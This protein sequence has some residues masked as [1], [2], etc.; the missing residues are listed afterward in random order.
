MSQAVEPKRLNRALGL[1]GALFIVLS[2]ITPASSVFIIVPGVIGLSG[3]GALWSFI[4]AAVIGLVMAF[5]YAELS[6]AFPTAGGEYTMIGRTMGPF[7]GFVTMVLLM[8]TLVLIIAVIAFGVGQY[9]GVVMPGLNPLATAI[10]AI[11]LAAVIAALGI[12]QNAL[13]TGVFL[14]IELL[15]L[16]ILVVLG[17]GGAERSIG[18]V[19]STPQV[20]D[21]ATNALA[22]AP[23]A[24][25]LAATA[26]ALFAYNGYGGAAYFGEETK[27]AKRSIG[28]V[29]LW[30]LLVTVLAEVLPLIAVLMGSPDLQALLAAPQKIEYF[31]EAKGGHSL[32]VLVSLAIVV[33]IFNAVIAIMLQ[34]ARLLYSTARDKTWPGGINQPLARLHPNFAS[35]W[36]ATVVVAVLAALACFIDFNTLLVVTGTSLIVVYV[37]LCIGVIIG[38]NN[39]STANGH[40][41]MPGYPIPAVLALI[42]L[43]YIAYQNLMDAAFGRPS[44]A[45]TAII[46]AIA[47]VYYLVFLARREDWKQEAPM[48]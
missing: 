37:L 36:I 15:A 24:A 28:R 23:F 18:A 21:T 29:I 6:S 4:I 33:A 16:L 1:M 43:L 2:A 30:A 34:A 40:Y 14:A 22:P 39:G 8:V 31:L 42:A 3:T 11:L 38:R 26:V 32:T 17:F 13:I 20:L 44:F 27:D 48:E 41:R 45:A 19:L 9:L 25:I 5:V 46:M 7:W 47:A 35:P 12:K 10:V